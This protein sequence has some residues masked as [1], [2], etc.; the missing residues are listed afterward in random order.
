MTITLTEKSSQPIFYIYLH[1]DPLTDEVRYVGKGHD[2]RAYSFS[3]RKGHHKNWIAKLAKNNL[4]PKV[5]IFQ[6]KLTEKEALEQ[7]VFWIDYFLS[8]EERLTNATLGGE[9]TC[10]YKFPEELKKRL[11]ADKI[12][13]PAVEATKRAAELARGKKRPPEIG[14]KISKARK[15]M[16][17]SEEHKAN[18]RKARA[19]FFAQKKINNVNT[20]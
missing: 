2:R 20:P 12:G 9:G 5:E 14:A 18:L 3:H 11:N 10:G 16:K 19:L 13:K 8:V 6:D 15:G 7:E 4:K 1:L 17:F